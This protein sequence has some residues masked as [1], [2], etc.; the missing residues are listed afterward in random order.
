MAEAREMTAR[1]RMTQDG[2][3]RA[4]SA[5]QPRRPSAAGPEPPPGAAPPLPPPAAAQDALRQLVAQANAGD[6]EARNRLRHVLDNNPALWQRAGDLTATA[7]GA[8][9]EVISAGNHLV[10]ESMKRQLADLKAQLKGAHPTAL[11]GLLADQVALGWLASR[12]AEIEAA[13]AGDAAHPSALVHLKRAESAQKRFLSAS[14]TLATLRTLAGPGLAPL[15]AV[16]VF[17]PTTQTG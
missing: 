3:T 12:H 4:G 15:R 11:E 10:A 14:R 1:A 7:E 8:W 5:D 13:H 2:T 17:V 6:P 9:L 16:S